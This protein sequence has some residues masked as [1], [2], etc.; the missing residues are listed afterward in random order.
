MFG[1]F[2]N[3][4]LSFT[5]Q[6]GIDHHKGCRNTQGGY[7]W[8]TNLYRCRTLCRNCCFVIKKLVLCTPLYLQLKPL[9]LPC[10]VQTF[11]IYLSN[12]LLQEVLGTF[13]RA[14][15][16]QRLIKQSLYQEIILLQKFNDISGKVLK[17]KKKESA[18][19]LRKKKRPFFSF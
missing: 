16:P 11:Q 3:F 9:C 17:P 8:H 19:N 12:Y 14:V 13:G 2:V 6:S 10:S 18:S 4:G 5:K 15:F 7:G 1:N